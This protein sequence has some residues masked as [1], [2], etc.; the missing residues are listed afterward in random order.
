MSAECAPELHEGDWLDVVDGDG[1]WNVAQVLRLPTADSVEVMY[2]CWGDVYNE[3]LPRDSARIAPFH[4]H[5]WA[6]KCWAKLDTWPWWPALLTVRTPGSDRGSQNLRLEE[7]LLV[8]FLDSIEF[9]ERCRCWVTKS[10]VVPFQSDKK[11]RKRRKRKMKGRN[12][13]FSTTLLARCD[14]RED[15][16]EFVEGTLPVKYKHNF[17]PPTEQV[18]KEMGEQIWLRGFAENRVNHAATH[19]YASVIAG[20]R[21]ANEGDSRQIPTRTEEK[22]TRKTATGDETQTPAQDTG[23][24]TP[25]EEKSTSKTVPCDR[26]QTPAQDTAIPDADK[27]SASDQAKHAEN[28]VA[29]PEKRKSTARSPKNRRKRPRPTDDNDTSEGTDTSRASASKSPREQTKI[30]DEVV[31]QAVTDEHLEEDTTGIAPNN[32]DLTKEACIVPRKYGKT[33]KVIKTTPRRATANLPPYTPPYAQILLRMKSCNEQH[34]THTSHTSDVR[35]TTKILPLATTGT[36][37]NKL[38]DSQQAQQPCID[39]RSASSGAKS[40]DG[41][42]SPMKNLAQ[43]TKVTVK[44][45]NFFDTMEDALED[46]LAELAEKAAKAEKMLTKCATLHTTASSPKPAHSTLTQRNNQENSQREDNNNTPDAS[47][48][49]TPE[50]RS[51]QA[52]DDKISK[53]PGLSSATTRAE[54]D[55]IKAELLNSPEVQAAISRIQNPSYGWTPSTAKAFSGASSSLSSE[56]SCRAFEKA[57]SRYPTQRT[58]VGPSDPKPSPWPPSRQ[59]GRSWGYERERSLLPE[60]PPADYSNFGFSVND[61]FSMSQ[62]YRDLYPKAFN[63]QQL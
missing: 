27:T 22:D 13:Q 1:I 50:R 57:N 7:R 9:T 17:T 12:L 62:W 51:S 28:S 29:E 2:D 39:A 37:N 52:L 21:K 59:F 18:R 26:T 58:V 24:P 55:A 10:K 6:V 35:H 8:D 42:V 30:G 49:P 14:A 45:G 25:A 11:E 43:M 4:T 5:T 3:E 46:K 19:A 53:Y 40:D 41:P 23:I 15:F 38:P 32:A 31:Q 36:A 63:F 34:T 20:E 44:T 33:P 48:V 60:S 61:N 16:P 47:R 56:S 54:F